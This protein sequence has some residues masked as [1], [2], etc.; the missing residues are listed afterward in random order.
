MKLSAFLLIVMFF[1]SCVTYDYDYKS[2]ETINYIDFYKDPVKNK[3]YSI[4]TYISVI[5][6][7]ITAGVLLGNHTYS[8][9]VNNGSPKDTAAIEKYS[10]IGLGVLAAGIG[11]YYLYNDTVNQG[12]EFI[13][14]YND[15]ELWYS[16]TVD[17]NQNILLGSYNDGGHSYVLSVN[18]ND[19]S[20][21][22]VESISQLR[23]IKKAL[24]LNPRKKDYMKIIADNSISKL[25]AD[26]YYYAYE[27]FGNIAPKYLEKAIRIARDGN[28]IKTLVEAIKRF[29]PDEPEFYY[30]LAS[31]RYNSMYDANKMND[32]SN[33]LNIFNNISTPKIDQTR[34]EFELEKNKL[35][36]EI[37]KE[38]ERDAKERAEIM[39]KKKI[40][41]EKKLLEDLNAIKEMKIEA[42]NAY[43]KL[44]KERKNFIRNLNTLDCVGILKVELINTDDTFKAF[45]Y[46][47]NTLEMA[48][49][50]SLFGD[51]Q[52]MFG[53]SNDI[54]DGKYYIPINKQYGFGIEI[55]SCKYTVL[56]IDS[57]SNQVLLEVINPCEN[58]SKRGEKIYI[59]TKDIIP[60]SK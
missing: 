57:N 32:I 22:Y 28:K 43:N 19:T 18:I 37:R 55:V 60:C 59:N 54:K 41:D 34:N 8:N 13:S 27:V 9:G 52:K 3:K 36:E 56:K 15:I 10:I 17:F 25:S 30:D 4:G 29:T 40:E 6:I 11:T 53:V 23:F 7:P 45:G 26:S 39:R 49:Q 12:Q 24:E 5:G 47:V 44:M 20:K 2:H 38:Q 35:D 14:T 48:L 58:N 31:E 46:L 1:H 51:L 50:N 16:H 42:I 21:I 33:W